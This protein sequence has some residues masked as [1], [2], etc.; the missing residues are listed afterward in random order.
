MI[1][2][3][4]LDPFPAL[5][6][7]DFS[8]ANKKII[9]IRSLFTVSSSSFLFYF[10]NG[11]TVS[12]APPKRGS[13]LCPFCWLAYLQLIYEPGPSTARRHMCKRLT[14]RGRQTTRSNVR[15][16]PPIPRWRRDARI[17]EFRVFSVLSKSSGRRW[18]AF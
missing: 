4:S 7:T 11:E 18:L 2:N 6:N 5:F 8:L 9:N 14:R 10:S 1:S 15:S 12:R 13:N 3:P 16:H 17:H